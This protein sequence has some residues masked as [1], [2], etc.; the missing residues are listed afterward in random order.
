MPPG[1]PGRST[2]DTVRSRTRSAPLSPSGSRTPT[3]RSARWS[4]TTPSSAMSLPRSSARW[5]ST[6][7]S[8]PT[9]PTTWR[10][11]GSGMPE[12]QG[13]RGQSGGRRR[14][15]QR[16]GHVRWEHFSHRHMWNM[17]MDARPDEVFERHREWRDLGRQLVEVNTAVQGQL[18]TLFTT[19]RGS[20]AMTAALGNTSLLAWAQEA[21]EITDEV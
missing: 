10:R 5:R 8:T 9:L 7:V 15:R 21:A 1:W 6:S 20:A 11:L 3:G 18:N 4:A 19:W 2:T 12:Q 16:L 14:G 13:D 17:I